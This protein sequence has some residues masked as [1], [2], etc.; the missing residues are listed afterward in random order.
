[1][2]IVGTATVGAG[3][4]L[5]G[6]SGK[7]ERPQ[8][9]LR[10]RLGLAAAAFAMVL[11]PLAYVAIAA[12]A[13]YGVYLQATQ[14]LFFGSGWIALIT[15]LSPLVAGAIIVLFMVKPLFARPA[16]A[17]E[18]LRLDP[19]DEPTLF[20][21]VRRICALTGA[22][23]PGEIRVDCQ[24][25]A[26]AA[27]RR[28]VLSFFSNDL[29]LT[30]G[31]PLAAGL[32]ADQLGGVLAH[33]F[34]HFSQ[35]AGM[36]LS[37][38]VRV[39]SAWFHRVVYERDEWDVK[40]DR[41]SRELDF[42]LAAMFWIA[43][44]GV[45]ISRKILWALM[46]IGHV[47]STF[48][49]RQMEFDADRYEVRLAGTKAFE[50][51]SLELEML[52]IA[53]SH[54]MGR[55]QQYWSE[56]RL[57]R[58]LPG[59]MKQCRAELAD[60]VSTAARQQLETAQT[61]R[62]DT[63]P[64]AKDRVA[65]AQKDGSSGV[66]RCARPAS[67]LFG[68]FERL[69]ER[70]TEQYFRVQL[71]IEY[72]AEQAL[73]LED[74]AAKSAA[75]EASQAALQELTQG[76]ARFSHPVRLDSQTG[77]RDAQATTREDSTEDGPGMDRFDQAWRR[78]MDLEQAD[79]LL[80]AGFRIRHDE[81][82]LSAG[83]HEAVDAAL[84]EADAALESAVDAPAAAAREIAA[85]L[86]AMDIR[87]AASGLADTHREW[88][89]LLAALHSLADAA[90]YV[91]RIGRDVAGLGAILQN[92]AGRARDEDLATAYANIA[93]S[94]VRNLNVAMEK[95]KDAAYPFEH[96][97]GT[98]TIV[99]FLLRDTPDDAYRRGNAVHG[100]AVEL[101]FRVL[102]RMAELGLEAEKLAESEKDPPE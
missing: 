37:Y 41:W 51:T 70:V 26:S 71:G 66:Y 102:A 33:E 50:E 92:A 101:Y 85:R 60:E 35:G 22:P 53:S 24:V 20:E 52:N 6:F 77:S 16:R 78:R 54:A 81:F 96:A 23:E 90:P 48:L 74:A 11:L 100:R 15:Y 21:F 3:A 10:Y 72:D 94:A 58:D 34:G 83:T 19:G 43:K 45:W 7:I 62:F 68:D 95:T 82:G 31:L 88:E 38:V 17:A 67:D 93:G 4:E 9:P 89:R 36:R 98:P 63:H 28:G 1:M 87:I 25:N 57:V 30:I 73:S 42:R 76:R 64:T 91:A 86:R 75:A 39:V 55:L 65:A 40:L 79:A 32:R 69:S 59:L 12:L 27:F 61:G 99:E 84:R 14:G 56:G 8:I 5:L 29:V 2:S 18:A 46:M 47:V 80:R 49:L 44:L 13:A 97:A